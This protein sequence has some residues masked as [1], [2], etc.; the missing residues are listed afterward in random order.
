[1]NSRVPRIGLPYRSANEEQGNKQEKILPYA[2][3]IEAAGGS[4]QLVSLFQ[5]QQLAKLA[6]ELDGFLFP[7]SSADVNPALYGESPGP[8]TASPDPR[9]EEVDRT[10]L[11]HA[12]R[13]G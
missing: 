13:E 3:A 4:P 10:L 6:G 5:P 7:G 11:E 9:R 12:F 2:Q 8:E 1:M